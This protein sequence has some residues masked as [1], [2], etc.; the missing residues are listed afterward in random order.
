[1]TRTGTFH[2]FFI[3]DI[4]TIITTIKRLT[5]VVLFVQ[6]RVDKGHR[7][8]GREN[9]RKVE[10]DLTGHCHFVISSPKPTSRETCISR[11]DSSLFVYFLIQRDNLMVKKR[12]ESDRTRSLILKTDEI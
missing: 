2:E 6:K 3:I 9:S 1:M 11:V 12:R 5:H 10:K 8:E 4:N 7:I